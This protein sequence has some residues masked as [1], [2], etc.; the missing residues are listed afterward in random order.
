MLAVR[1]LFEGGGMNSPIPRLAAYPPRQPSEAPSHVPLIERHALVAVP[2][3]GGYAC[4][5]CAFE[6][7]DPAEVAAHLVASQFE[8]V[9]SW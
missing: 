5:G 2:R 3:T 8:P 4:R 1:S 7:P 6:S 9:R